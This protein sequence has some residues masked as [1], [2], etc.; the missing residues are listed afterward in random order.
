M[1]VLDKN[2]QILMLKGEKGDTGDAGDY[3]TLQNKPMINNIELSGNKSASDLELVAEADLTE[4][5]NKLAGN[6]EDIELLQEYYS[7]LETD[8]GSLPELTTTDKTSLVNAVNEVNGKTIP[9]TQGGTGA[10]TATDARTNLEVRKAH[11]LYGNSTGSSGTVTL[12][13]TC[14]NFQYVEIYYRDDSN[15]YS[16][17]ECYEPNNKKIALTVVATTIASGGYSGTWMK[18]AEW[19]FSGTTL[20]LANSSEVGVTEFHNSDHPTSPLVHVYGTNHIYVC[21]VLGYKY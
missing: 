10:T 7:G 18:S 2:I 12:S 5:N 17:I 6:T 11:V 20:A 4:T 16:S 3:S 8:V 19:K 14:A 15:R 1:A 13:E 9:I 21:G